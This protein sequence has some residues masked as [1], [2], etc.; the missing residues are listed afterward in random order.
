[1]ST[2]PKTGIDTYLDR[3]DARLA[4]LDDDG[5]RAVFLNLCIGQTERKRERFEE[6]LD[7][8]HG[9]AIS[10][11]TILAGLHGRHADV[12]KSIQGRIADANDRL[13]KPGISGF[14]SA[15]QARRFGFDL[16]LEAAASADLPEVH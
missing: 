2:H 16:P 7:P 11:S 9:D 3:V 5:E 8:R 10:F 14:I 13:S 4:E 15:F 6:T 12:V 1:M